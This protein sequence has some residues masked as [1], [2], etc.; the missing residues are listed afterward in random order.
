MHGS[1][2]GLIK[3][4]SVNRDVVLNRPK[5]GRRAA[6]RFPTFPDNERSRASQTNA[7]SASVATIPS[8]AT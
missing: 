2:L 1:F 4:T 5:K 8:D 6:P 7:L 3:R